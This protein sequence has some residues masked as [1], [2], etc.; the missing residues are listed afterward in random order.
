MS[1]NSLE[2]VVSNLPSLFDGMFNELF[3][4]GTLRANVKI[5][6]FVDNEDGTASL[7]VDVPGISEEEILV[8]IK[9]GVVTIKAESEKKNSRR[10]FT[11]NYSVPDKLD[12]D[13][14]TAELKQGVLTL[15][16]KKL[17]ALEDTPKK[18]EVKSVK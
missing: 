5:S 4:L 16:F 15:T 18:I 6:S 9:N 17:P 13:S 1:N 14:A 2:K 12:I 3:S 8:E 11:Y 10:S 7:S